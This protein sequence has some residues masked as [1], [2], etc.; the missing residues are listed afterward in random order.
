M[1]TMVTNALSLLEVGCRVYMVSYGPFHGLKGT[2]KQVHAI[3]APEAEEPF[4]FYYI[5]LDIAQIKEPV[6]FQNH[7]VEIIIP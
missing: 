4:C 1:I 7:E 5:E 3:V 6:W 2:I